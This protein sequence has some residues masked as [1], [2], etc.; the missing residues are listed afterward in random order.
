MEKSSK[1]ASVPAAAAAE[2]AVDPYAVM[3]PYFA[4]SR[5]W[6]DLWNGEVSCARLCKIAVESNKG[7][8]QSVIDGTTDMLDLLTVEELEEI[9]PDSG[10]SAPY[11]AIYYDRPRIVK[12]LHDRGIDFQKNCDG[13][14]FGTCI[15]YAVSYL[16]YE[17]LE[18]LEQLEYDISCPC[19]E[20]GQT[21]LQRAE[22]MENKELHAHLEF[23]MTRRVRVH[24]FMTK[25]CMRFLHRTRY[26]RLYRNLLVVQRII[27]G[28]IGRCRAKNKSSRK[29]ANLAACAMLDFA[30]LVFPCFLFPCS[31]VV[32]VSRVGS[33][34][35]T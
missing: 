18:L 3:D 13:M 31:I 7:I 17:I 11:L 29:R 14:G 21:P 19:D 20:F 35:S 12:Y 5:K 10:C 26:L 24:I 27:R 28:F 32:W 16:R 9:D 33:L 23:L 15:F 2:D 30:C 34:C 4:S 6:G 8:M 1:K 22:K 25:N